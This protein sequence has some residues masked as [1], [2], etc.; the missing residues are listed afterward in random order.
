MPEVVTL[1]F[2]CGKST[3]K[4]RIKCLLPAEI[5]L[6]QVQIAGLATDDFRVIKTVGANSPVLTGCRNQLRVVL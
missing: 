2:G 3:D 1:G 4:I 5:L 6:K